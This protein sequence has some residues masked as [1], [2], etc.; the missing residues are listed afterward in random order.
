MVG[1]IMRKIIFFKY[2]AVIFI[3][4]FL[5]TFLLLENRYFFSFD[6]KTFTVWNTKKGVYIIPDKYYKLNFPS[7]NYLKTS[8]NTDLIIFID[9][10]NIFYIFSNNCDIPYKVDVNLKETKYVLYPYT[11]K[12]ENYNNL[13]KYETN[14][15]YAVFNYEALDNWGFVRERNETSFRE[16]L[17]ADLKWTLQ[18]IIIGLL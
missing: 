11:D 8:S 2:L 13:K 3:V 1:F 14:N 16:I 17:T 6:N 5:I 15:Q 18:R 9:K 4:I 12:E 10:N 7:N